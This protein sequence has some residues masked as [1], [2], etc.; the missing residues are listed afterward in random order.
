[1]VAENNSSPV[2]FLCGALGLLGGV[3]FNEVKL[4]QC[5]HELMEKL[6]GGK[7]DEL[8]DGKNFYIRVS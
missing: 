2:W 8:L 7:L 6:N 1:M 5:Y 3:F 4:L